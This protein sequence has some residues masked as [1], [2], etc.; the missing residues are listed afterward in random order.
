MYESEVCLRLFDKETQEWMKELFE[1]LIIRKDSIIKVQDYADDKDY[2]EELIEE[3]PLFEFL[4]EAEGDEG[5]EQNPNDQA[6]AQAQQGEEEQQEPQDGQ[7]Q[8]DGQEQDQGQEEQ[9]AE[10]GEQNPEED[11]QGQEGTEDGTDGMEETD[12]EESEEDAK[13]KR[14][15][16]FYFNQFTDLKSELNRIK[17]ILET[18]RYDF[19]DEEQ[20]AV[21]NSIESSLNTTLDNIDVILNGKIKSIEVDNLKRLFEIFYTKANLFI[22]IIEGFNKKTK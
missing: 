20:S 1:E 7:Q 11:G 18:Y 22:E 13:E 21:I 10:D 6:Q 3:S 14:I 5:Q 15:R 12:P 9:G 17:D 2:G 8:D 4:N 16:L 19:K